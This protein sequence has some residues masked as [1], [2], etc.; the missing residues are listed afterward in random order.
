VAII[1][2]GLWRDAFA[3]APDVV[4]RVLTIGGRPTT[5]IGVAPPGGPFVADADV[6]LPL[7]PSE[8]EVRFDY[9]DLDVIGRLA[10]GVT[11][12]AAR[13]EMTA[14]TERVAAEL[15]AAGNQGDVTGWVP[16]L[17]SLHDAVVGTTAPRTLSLLFVAAVVL[18][19]VACANVS[20][21]LLA[22]TSGRVHELA[23]RAALGGGRARIRRQLLV[24][25]SCLAAGGAILGLA[26]SA[27]ALPILKA[28][29]L[30]ALPR[31]T[32]IHIDGAALLAALVATVVTAML[33]GLAPSFRASPA[34]LSFD[35]RDAAPTL[36]RRPRLQQRV[37]IAGQ[38]ALSIVLLTTAGL[39]A[40][41]L[42]E[43][44]SVDLGF[45]P[46]RVL[47]MAFA[48][49]HAPELTTAALLERLRRLPDVESAAATSAAP[50]DAWNTSLNVFPVGPA[51]VPPTTSVQSDWR[52]VSPGYFDAMSTPLL[53]GRDFSPHDDSR[54]AKVIIV[55]ETLAQRIWGR[56][57]PIGRQLDLGGGGGEPA[58]V[59]GLVRDVRGHSPAVSP[60]PTYYVSMYRGLWGPVTIVVRTRADVARLVPL[61][62]AELAAVDPAAPLFD[63]MTMRQRVEGPLMPQ[64]LV[65]G[66]L[67]GFALA[68]TL[69]AVIGMYG[70]VSYATGQRLREIALRLALGA[71]RWHVVRLLL[72]E[73]VRLVM[74]GIAAGVLLAVPAVRSMRPL[75]AGTV[76]S[77]PATAALAV[78][79]L[80]VAALVASAIPI[81]RALRANP[82]VV[83]RGE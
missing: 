17:V 21:L 53:A 48:P 37:L 78:A 36:A 73:G 42:A 60:V 12:A 27:V 79:A 41:A 46:S 32:A 40:H 8:E 64:R 72:G 47:S 49:T 52:V 81:R 20:G 50:M 10:P 26:M 57:S 7:V 45:D 35:L 33:A 29:T 74:I 54:A 13:A 22:R 38:L 56:E 19:L 11:L 65:M 18:L 24:E 44:R 51:I 76:T 70:L 9:S 71:S 1:S 68:A 30:T 67:A 2:N 15:V 66:L 3:A 80:A 59:V 16:R 23:V 4:G 58:T 28:S 6:F 83:L 31:A 61:V 69:L 62:R 75:L 5:I 63:V 25:T 39:A 43:L 14:L 55:N 34:A 77:G 82:A